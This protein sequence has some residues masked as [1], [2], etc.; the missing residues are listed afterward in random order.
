MNTIE[1]RAWHVLSGAKG[2][3][4]K[5]LWKIADFL[6]SRNQTA[7]WLLQHCGEIDVVLEMKKAGIVIPGFKKNEYGELEKF[8][9]RQVTVLHPLHADFPPRLRALKDMS[10]L[11]AILYVRGN[12]AILNRPAVA[13]VGMRQAGEA[14]LAAAA[15]LAA[16]AAARD[17][18]IVS[19]YAAGIDTAAHLA[20]LRSK[21]T[22]AMVL[23]EGIHHFQTRPELLDHLTIDNILVIS[24]FEPDAK[25]AAYMAMM[26]N[27][28]VGALSEAMVVVVS[29][30]R[31]DADGRMSGSFD[32]GMSALKMGI[33][34]F[35]VSPH[36]FTDP[37]EGNRQLI[38]RGCRA[39]DPAAGAAPI[40]ETLRSHADQK[41]QPEQ[42]SLFEKVTSDE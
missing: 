21:G 18:T 37:P 15:A 11:P 14:A 4:A 23:P 12:I 19:G 29:G 39:W 1:G 26:R 5:T 13:I 34:V 36:F 38:A 30:P 41:S 32:A 35:V 2:V 33:P 42:L 9:N 28:L 22:T 16:E 17:V 25:W 40:I 6:A 27:K 7:S 31:R 3:G 20:A 24:Q 8:A 10:S